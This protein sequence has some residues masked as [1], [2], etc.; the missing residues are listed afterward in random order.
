M[1]CTA[2][3]SRET[4][5]DGDARLGVPAEELPPSALLAGHAGGI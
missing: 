1:R 4:R 2:S 5:I 3:V